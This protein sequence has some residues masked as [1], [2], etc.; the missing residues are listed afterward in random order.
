MHTSTVK[1]VPHGV[2]LG[3]WKGRLTIDDDV[4][5][6]HGPDGRHLSIDPRNVKRSSFNGNNGL[7]VFRLHDG[8]KVRIQSAGRLLS[9]DRSQAGKAANDHLRELL[10]RQGVRV[11]G[12]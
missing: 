2:V 3:G 4:I 9:A 8:T 11:F 5:T 7:W 1:V 12:L 10:A 6:V